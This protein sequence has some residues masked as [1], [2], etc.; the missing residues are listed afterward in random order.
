MFPSRCQQD[1]DDC[2]YPPRGNR[3][4]SS[5]SVGSSV[6]IGGLATLSNNFFVLHIWKHLYRPRNGGHAFLS[7]AV[8]VYNIKCSLES[9]PG[10]LH[11]KE[12]TVA[13]SSNISLVLKF[14]LRCRWHTEQ[15][16]Y[17]ADLRELFRELSNEPYLVIYTSSGTIIFFCFLLKARVDSLR[18]RISQEGQDQDVLK[19][20]GSVALI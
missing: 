13:F 6:C 16:E 9:V 4:R 18:L 5:I 2:K 20:L 17:L 7:L 14:H 19:F 10:P 8:S 12:S 1:E 3:Q 11:T 15:P